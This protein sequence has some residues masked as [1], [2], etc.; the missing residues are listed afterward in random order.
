MGGT[1][2]IAAM[3]GRPIRAMFGRPIE[4]PPAF[5]ARYPELAKV[6]W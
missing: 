6:Q 1:D 3:I 5:I 2:I 4:L